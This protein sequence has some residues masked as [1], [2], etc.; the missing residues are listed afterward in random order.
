MGKKDNHVAIT[1]SRHHITITFSVHV[2][3]HSSDYKWHVFPPEAPEIKV[4]TQPWREIK[5]LELTASREHSVHRSLL[6][7]MIKYRVFCFVYLR[8]GFYPH[9]VLCM[10]NM[11]CLI[12]FSDHNGRILGF[13]QICCWPADLFQ[14]PVPIFALRSLG[15]ALMKCSIICATLTQLQSQR[16]Y[17]YCVSSKSMKSSSVG[18]CR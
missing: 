6:S 1:I 5:H 17:W 16:M 7:E 11:S 18:L 3:L 2:K 14:L 13:T 12:W 4:A 15:K 9:F 10:T 8:H